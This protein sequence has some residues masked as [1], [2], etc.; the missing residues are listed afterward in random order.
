MDLQNIFNK[1]TV[2]GSVVKLPNIQLERD[3]YNEV[4]KQFEAAGGK[5]NRGKQGFLFK[6]DEFAQNAIDKLN[7]G[8]DTVAIKK[9]TQF[10]ATPD[11]IADK[12]AEKLF[13]GFSDDK[14]KNF[15][16]LEP[17]AGQGALIK[18]VHRKYPDLKVDCFEIQEENCNVLSKFPN[19]R[20]LGRDFL[21]ASGR[22]Q[23]DLIIAN[24]PFSKNQDIKHFNHMLDFLK[25]GGRIA[26]I[27]SPHWTF[28]KDNLSKEFKAFVDSHT[29]DYEELP[30]GAFKESGTNFRTVMITYHD[31]N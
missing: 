18:A 8:T 7:S 20:L 31:D 22:N 30:Q 1:C 10:Y 3:T 25:P 13:L 15:T 19:V 6:S 29:V 11:G 9:D 4:K 27:T 17:S 21:E 12:L 5:W 28:A 2:D 23:Y 16:V 26:C 24:P 14:I